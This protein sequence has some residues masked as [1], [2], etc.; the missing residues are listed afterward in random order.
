M[1]TKDSGTYQGD[2]FC[3]YFDVFFSQ[4]LY[5]VKIIHPEICIDWA[6]FMKCLIPFKSRTEKINWGDGSNAARVGSMVARLCLIPDVHKNNSQVALDKLP[7][8]RTC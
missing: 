6:N 5:S 2:S 1:L 3:N 7:Y 8:L 4:L